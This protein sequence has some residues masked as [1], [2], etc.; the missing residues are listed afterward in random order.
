MLYVY[1]DDKNMVA[2]LSV[3]PPM[4]LK[5]ALMKPAPVI[6]CLSPKVEVCRICL[7]A[8][9]GIKLCSDSFEKLRKVFR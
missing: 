1:P 7:R 5:F 9:L 4:M 6:T 2:T 8:E 3:V